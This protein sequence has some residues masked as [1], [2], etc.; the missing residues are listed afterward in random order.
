MKKVVSDRRASLD[1]DT[2]TKPAMRR[3][4][5]D[6]FRR[7]ATISVIPFPNDGAEIPDTP[8]LTLVVTDPGAEWTGTGGLR[9]QVAEWTRNRGKSPRLYP[10]ALV[11]CLKKPGRE[12]REKVELMLAW[13]RVAR[14]IAD[15]TLGGEFDRSDRADL[16]SKVRDAEEAAKDGRLPFR[17]P[18]RRT[19]TGW[20]QGYRSRRGALFQWR[21]VVWSG[22]G[23][24]QVRSA[25]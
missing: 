16:Q 13:R 7:G 11:W 22:C 21:N 25:A 4:V 10:G 14:E 18:R 24:A 15:G 19:G 5:E 17:C 1:E 8:R 9:T 12:L 2:E 23:C 20:A 3:L 6:E